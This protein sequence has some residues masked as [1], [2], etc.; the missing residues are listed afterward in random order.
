MLEYIVSEVMLKMII[1]L[2]LFARFSFKLKN[3]LK[4]FG[5]GF[6]ARRKVQTNDGVSSVLEISLLI[7]NVK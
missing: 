2:L 3:H 5:A 6:D 1:A 7:K 4:N